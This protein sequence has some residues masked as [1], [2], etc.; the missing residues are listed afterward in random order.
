MQFP[1]T[2]EC[3]KAFNRQNV[4][5]EKERQQR[6]DLYRTLIK[7]ICN[8]VE[9]T[10]L[11]SKTPV[12]QYVWKKIG[13]IGQWKMLINHPNMS[14]MIITPIGV[15]PISYC[16]RNCHPSD[17]ILNSETVTKYLPEFIDLLKDTFID[18]EIIID[19]LKT[20]LIIDWS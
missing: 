19:P 7:K 12:T 17:L 5:A 3:L 6:F 1:I 2:R 18:C 20:Y 8:D 10:L 9:Q 16:D 11:N 13:I 15:D 4:I 14:N